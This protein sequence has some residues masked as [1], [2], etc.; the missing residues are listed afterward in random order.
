MQ[1]VGFNGVMLSIG[2]NIHRYQD[3][4]NLLNE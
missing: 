2:S 1:W 3:Y 4:D